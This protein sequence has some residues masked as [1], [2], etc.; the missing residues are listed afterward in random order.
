LLADGR[1]SRRDGIALAG[2]YVLV[3]LGFFVA[4]DR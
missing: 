4:G 3:A 2:V 1:G